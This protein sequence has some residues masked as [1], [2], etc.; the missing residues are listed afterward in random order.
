MGRKPLPDDERRNMISWR[1]YSDLEL[2]EVE[3]AATIAQAKSVTAYVRDESLKAA[4]KVNKA[5]ARTRKS[6]RKPK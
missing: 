1:L 4:R 5:R 2:A 3:S 6:S